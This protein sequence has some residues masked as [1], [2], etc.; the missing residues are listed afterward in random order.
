MTHV[1]CGNMKVSDG[2]P[3]AVG[4]MNLPGCGKSIW[5]ARCRCNWWTYRVVEGHCGAGP[6]A[7][8]NDELTCFIEDQCGVP[9]SVGDDDLS[10]L[11][12]EGQCGQPK[13]AVGDDDLPWQLKVNV[14]CQMLLDMMSSPGRWRSLR[15]AKVCGWKWRPSPIVEGQCGLPAA[16]DDAHLI[17]EGQCRLPATVGDDDLRG[18]AWQW[19][20]HVRDRLLP[21]A[22][23]GT[24][25]HDLDK[26]SGHIGQCKKDIT[27]LLTHWSCVFLALAQYP[28]ISSPTMIPTAGSTSQFTTVTDQDRW[29]QIQHLSY[30]CQGQG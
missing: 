27:P 28:S 29:N 2:L 21:T 3:V 19:Q 14:V 20:H 10:Y 11:V 18:E 30:E 25:S 7:V 23:I 12:P 6:D 5:C 17:V 15:S 26:T 16:I 8:G 1:T 22:V 13:S 24:T 9:A 4:M